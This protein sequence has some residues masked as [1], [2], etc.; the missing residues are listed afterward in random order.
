LGD[1]EKWP[2]EGS[3]NYNAILQLDLF[4]KREEKW[5]EVPYI[6]LFFY[7]WDHPEWVHNCYLDAQTLAILCKPEDKH[8]E[9][10]PASPLPL[11]RPLS[12]LLHPLP[13]LLSHP[14]IWNLMMDISP[15]NRQW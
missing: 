3:L 12:L 5:T 7:L 14:N 10:G 15:F 4:Y 8:G 1:Q 13:Y 11:T 9:G 6:Q 2:S